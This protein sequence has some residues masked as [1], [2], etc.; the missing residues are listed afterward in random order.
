MNKQRMKIFWSAFTGMF[1]WEIFPSYIFPLLN[2]FS[3]ICLASQGANP[4]A[5]DV[6][7]NLFGGAEGNE[8]LGILNFSFDWQVSVIPRRLRAYVDDVRSIL[9]RST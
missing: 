4:G 6:I 5:L 3:I 8:G 9:A 1:V 7:T 2:G